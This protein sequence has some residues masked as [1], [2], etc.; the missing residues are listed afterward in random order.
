[1]NRGLIHVYTGT[2]KGKTTAAIGLAVR[3]IG[4]GFNVCYCSFHKNPERYGYTEMEQLKKLGAKV[5]N[6]AKGH[7]YLNICIDPVVNGR[8]AREGL[9]YLKALIQEQD[10]DMLILDE[11]LIS[12][13]D[14]LVPEEQILEFI[15]NK[16]E[17]LE[18]VLTGRGATENVISRADYVSNVDKVK[19]PYDQAIKARKCIEF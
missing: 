7:P 17:K 18:L 10:F 19:H 13:R 1:M 2:G 14:G 6:F 11:I 15:E 5:I 16:P 12:V 4:G 8:E 3:A 9:E